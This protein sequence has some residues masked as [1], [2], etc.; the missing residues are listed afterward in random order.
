MKKR[1]LF[2][3]ALLVAMVTIVQS[4]TTFAGGTGTEDDPYQIATAEQFEDFA[5]N[6]VSN[7]YSNT[8]KGKY[9]KITADLDFTGVTH[10]VNTQGAAFCGT[11]NGDNHTIK[12]LVVVIDD[13]RKS[14]LFSINKG[15]IKN[16]HMDNS[17]SMTVAADYSGKPAFGSF[18]IT[19]Y[20]FIKDCTSACSYNDPRTGSNYSEKVGG[21]AGNVYYDYNFYQDTGLY[22]N[23]ENCSFSGTLNGNI[24]YV[25]G[26]AGYINRSCDIINCQFTGA[27]HSTFSSNTG[28]NIGGIIGRAY[29]SDYVC[30]NCVTSGTITTESANLTWVGAICGNPYL[31][32]FIKTCTYDTEKAVVTVGGKVL[33]GGARAIG[34]D[35]PGT[36]TDS[37][38]AYAN[39]YEL[40]FT[41]T[42]HWK[43]GWAS[44]NHD[45]PEGVKA[46]IVT[47]VDENTGTVYVEEV[48]HIYASVA[49]L[50]ERTN[51]DKAAYY[52]PINNDITESQKREACANWSRRF[53]TGGYLDDNYSTGYYLILH[54]DAFVRLSNGGQMPSGTCYIDLSR[55]GK[56][57]YNNFYSR[58]EIVKGGD[59]TGISNMKNVKMHN[60]I[61]D[62]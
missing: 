42:N 25:G 27:I 54:N 26:I 49:M 34:T 51:T 62:L 11:L 35:T 19:N 37:N 2:L 12:N 40:I 60:D 14:G 45:M 20:G 13:G 4:Q 30:K 22:P 46:Y 31:A 32:I 28:G 36:A 53:T 58:F 41:G 8:T 9:Y 44:R 18:A 23:I 15:T 43:T 47:D 56:V 33:P 1:L 38:G 21:I 52:A 17:C 3:S 55:S 24:H 61:Y 10:R 57:Y 6:M 5:V 16:L 39:K 59:A 50:F 48:Q 7:S 29:E